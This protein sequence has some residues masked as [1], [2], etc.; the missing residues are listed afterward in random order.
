MH[1]LHKW[2]PN[3]FAWYLHLH[4][5]KESLWRFSLFKEKLNKWLLAFGPF[6]YSGNCFLFCVLTRTEKQERKQEAVAK[7]LETFDSIS[8]KSR[9]R[10][11]CR[12]LKSEPKTMKKNSAIISSS[13]IVA[14]ILHSMTPDFKPHWFWF[15][16]LIAPFDI[17]HLS[18]A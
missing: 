7:C 13:S 11:R 16:T 2:N 17:L 6:M 12:W 10:K 14:V 9:G 18:T 3:L 8:D 1:L 4:L 5:T 15:Y